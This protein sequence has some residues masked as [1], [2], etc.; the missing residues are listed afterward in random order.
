MKLEITLTIDDETKELLRKLLLDNCKVAVASDKPVKPKIDYY[1]N[2]W[3]EEC[4][5]VARGNY[6]TAHHAY[7]HYFVWCDKKGIIWPASQKGFGH[8]MTKLKMER[9]K[10]GGSYRYLN[11]DFASKGY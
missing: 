3:A 5:T 4:L 11:V 9:C 6:I 1:V 7:E 2:N 8:V 10:V